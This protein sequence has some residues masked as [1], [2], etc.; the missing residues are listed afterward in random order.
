[1]S[2][3]LNENLKLLKE[4][5]PALEPLLK[6][7]SSPHLVCESSKS[8]EPVLFEIKGEIKTPLH[9][10]YDPLGEA[11]KNAEAFFA[12]KKSCA[13]FFGAGLGYA[14]MEIARRMPDA[15]IIIIEPDE[16]Y[17]F[18]TLE[19]VSW[20]D[21]FNH[22]KISLVTGADEEAAKKIIIQHNVDDIYFFKNKNIMHHAEKYFLNL[23]SLL[24][25]AEDVQNVNNS[26]LEKFASLWMRNSLKNLRTYLKSDGVKKYFSL[27]QN[28]PL[29]I[30][31]AGPSLDSILPKLG[32]IKKRA[33]IVCVDT[34]LHACLRYGVEP[35]FIL[36]ADP[37]YSAYL[38]LEFLRAPESVLIAE[39]AVHPAV[40]RFDCR[41]VTV[42]SSFFPIGAWFEKR[43]GSKGKLA[44]GGSVAT[45]AWDF[46]RC[47]GAQEIFL[48]GMD[49]G[50]PKKQTHIKGS[51]FEEAAHRFS[52]KTY[53]GET[54][55]ISYLMQ[56][57]LGT[58]HDYK[59]NRLITDVRMELFSHWFESTIK[60]FPEVK[61][62]SLTSESLAIK[63]I[64]SFSLK[65][66]LNKNNVENLKNQFFCSA[67]KNAAENKTDEKKFEEVL[68]V[69]K[70]E[71]NFLDE[72][73]LEGIK[74]C[75][76]AIKN[77]LLSGEVFAKLDEIDA[78]ILSSSA[79]ETAAL[80]FPTKKQLEE[81]CRN[82]PEEKVMHQLYY[83]RTI[84]TLLHN[85]VKK[86]T[87]RL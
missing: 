58:S 38:H 81:N 54:H 14:C 1:M 55:S 79:K 18:T 42:C 69:F 64:T 2:S 50:F 43:L 11:K 37:Q 9:S 83:S 85:S 59:G 51:Q 49:L 30:L 17:F 80:V 25:K 72:K 10:K 84:Y 32:E 53:S 62:Y 29:V 46:A 66:F 87:S 75:N 19:N 22:K 23:T 74:Q 48:A 77:R 7:E 67:E 41:E 6:K 63:G 82:L 12:S 35:D 56:V 5:F 65:D 52:K 13:I 61:T 39:S 68:S 78:Q 31:A 20:K 36:I 16:A 34:A 47:C 15:E 8:G 45:T 24:E 44:S 27:A 86:I 57:P 70:N 4:R 76:R 21:I 60:N 73:A 33:L 26:T 71:L 28:I 40:F 3:F